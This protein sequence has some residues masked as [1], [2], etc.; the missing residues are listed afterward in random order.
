MSQESPK[1]VGGE[2]YTRKEVAQSFSHAYVFPG[3]GSQRVG[4]GFEL[5]EASNAARQVFDEADAALGFSLSRLIFEGPESELQ[6]TVNSQPAILIVSIAYLRAMDEALDYNMEPPMFV[7]GHSLGQYTSLVAADAISFGDAVRLVRKRGRLMQDASE[8]C[9]GGMAAIIGLDEYAFEQICSETG[10]VIANI[11]ADDQIVISGN[12]LAVAKAMDLAHARGARRTIS[13]P[14]S[15][16]FHSPLMLG[17]RNGLAEA[18]SQLNLQD[19]K[20]PIVANSNSKILNRAEDV[21]WELVNGLC[22]PVRW[23]DSVRLMVQ[24][25]VTHVVEVGPGS[26]LSSLVRR[27]VKDIQTLN[28]DDS[29]DSI[30]KFAEM[31]QVLK[32]T[33]T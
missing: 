2:V 25:G 23:R 29:L 21:W 33:Q 26:V 4:M 27:I 12:K 30:K 19:P 1:G 15:G 18:I 31:Q 28:V 7:A 16:A 11:N 8:K 14:V 5:Y 9:P 10:V 32:A 17:A 22:A 24:S 3:Q 13:L 6:N 20:I